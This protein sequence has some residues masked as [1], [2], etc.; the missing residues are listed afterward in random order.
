MLKLN[1]TKNNILYYLTLS[2]IIVLFSYLFF[3]STKYV[4][5]YWTFSQAHINYSDGFVKRGL[6]GTFALF[7]ENNFKIK[8]INTFNLFFIV[9]YLTN[10][11]LF[12]IIK[13]YS[14]F[15]YSFIFLALSPTLILFSFNDL[16]GYQRFDS[17]S[18]FLILFHTY[19][20]YLY[21][22]EKINFKSYNKNFSLLFFRFF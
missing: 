13:Q 21:R 15:N 1:M 16:G 4:I 11:I 19:L 3:L 8:F 9:F 17:I 10:I 20:I 12:L 7:L 6:F 22:T 2:F 18:I 5:N 14:R